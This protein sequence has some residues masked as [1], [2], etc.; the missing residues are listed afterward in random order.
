MVTGYGWGGPARFDPVLLKALKT[1]RAG[2]V[3]YVCDIGYG[4]SWNIKYTLLLWMA[5]ARGDGAPFRIGADDLKHYDD[6]GVV[7]DVAGIHEDVEEVMA[8]GEYGPL[9]KLAGNIVID[10]PN[11]GMNI[12]DPNL[13][14]TIPQDKG[15]LLVVLQ[16]MVES[17]SLPHF[18]DTAIEA[19]LVALRS[20]P[21]ELQTFD[22]L[23]QLVNHDPRKRL[24]EASDELSTLLRSVPRETLTRISLWPTIDGVHQRID[25]VEDYITATSALVDTLKRL[26]GGIYGNMFNGKKSMAKLM[27][28]RVVVSDYSKLTDPAI[29][30]A[31]TVFQQIR[32]AAM[33]RHDKRFEVN[34][35][36][37]DEAHRFW[38]IPAFA[39]STAHMMKIIRS[40][41]NFMLL[42]TQRESDLHATG[43][44][45]AINS[46][47]DVAMVVVGHLKNAEARRLAERYSFSDEIVKWIQELQEGQFLIFIHG[48]PPMFVHIP[49]TDLTRQ[50]AETDQASDRNLTLVSENGEVA[51]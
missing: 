39:K 45:L 49:P 51:S 3:E 17:L 24:T 46:L 11:A 1:V 42:A 20:L 30:M 12:L 34:V 32:A 50:I 13:G 43:S 2:I 21:E 36:V 5:L 40:F 44:A 26:K 35:I 10:L 37:L 47:D 25:P 6:G 38:G 41:G 9:A 14:M 16:L 18:W 31:Q 19:S 4:K 8:G 15:M 33:A 23:L 27:M 28:Q 7:S 29:A 48:Q 22:M